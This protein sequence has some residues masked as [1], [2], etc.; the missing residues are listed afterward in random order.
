MT[1][2]EERGHQVWQWPAL[3]SFVFDF[4]YALRQLRR[5]PSFAT[6]AVLILGLGIGANTAV[7]SLLDKLLF[8]PLPF[9]DLLKFQMIFSAACGSDLQSIFSVGNGRPAT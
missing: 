4:R 1:S 8:Q 5:E 3:E 7:F 2:V 6:V 9:H